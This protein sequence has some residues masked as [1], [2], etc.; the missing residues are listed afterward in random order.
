MRHT[1]PVPP[2]APSRSLLE[3]LLFELNQPSCAEQTLN[4]HST[5]HSSSTTTPRILCP[6]LSAEAKSSEQ[7][8]Q[9][10][11][12]EA[13]DIL[14]HL[15]QS[16]Q[17]SADMMPYT[18]IKDLQ[19]CHRREEAKDAGPQPRAH[20]HSAA[21]CQKAPQPITHTSLSHPQ[22]RRH[23]KPTDRRAKGG[24]GKKMI[25]EEI[26]LSAEM[27]EERRM[28]RNQAKRLRTSSANAWATRSTE[29]DNPAPKRPQQGKNMK[30]LRQKLLG[31]RK[32][33]EDE[34]EKEEEIVRRTESFKKTSASSSKEPKL[35]PDG[36]PR[37]QATGQAQGTD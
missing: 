33:D 26:S 23:C 34:E 21:P 8:Q 30:T 24:T 17:Q 9:Q 2:S 16:L 36:T 7:Q 27:F 35:S 18:I 31:K 37:F 25:L 22:Y 5:Q 19:E 29:Q 6:S 4:G 14:D 1:V 11:D 10:P 12:G 3:Q 32:R 13:S 20:A 15:M 28:T